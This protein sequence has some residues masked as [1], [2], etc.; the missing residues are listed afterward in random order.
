MSGGI[1]GGEGEGF[2]LSVKGQVHGY[3]TAQAA[4]NVG[5]NDTIIYADSTQA[6]GIGYGASAKSTLGV[7]GDILAASSA[8][9]LSA[10]TASATSGHVLTS[11]G[12]ASLPTYQ[13]SAGGVGDMLLGTVQNITAAK[14]FNDS[15]RCYFGTGNDANIYHNGSDL[16]IGCTTGNIWVDQNMIMASNDNLAFQIHTNQTLVSGAITLVTNVINS[17]TEGGAASDDFTTC[18]ATATGKSGQGKGKLLPGN[19]TPS[20]LSDILGVADVTKLSN[21]ALK[22]LLIEG[23]FTVKGRKKGGT[24]Y[25]KTGGQ[26]SRGTGAA[27]RGFGKA[28]YS[29]KLY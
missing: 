14:T 3:D 11:T 29:H 8:N 23:G 16:Y 20:Q 19:V 10:I 18:N 17:D 7:T 27:L 2:D 22:G 21:K 6:A 25:R 13:A 5:A 1:G 15:I 24:V 26:V 9:T 12:A 4:V 28:T